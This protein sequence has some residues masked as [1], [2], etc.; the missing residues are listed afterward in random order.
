MPSAST[1]DALAKMVW[2]AGISVPVITCWTKQARENSDPDMARIMD[3]CNFYPRWKIVEELTPAL[4][5]LRREEPNSPLAITELQG[6]WFSEI[7]GVLS[8]NQEGVD[9]AQINMLTKTASGAGGYL[10][11]LLHG[12]RRDQFRLGG[13]EADHH[14]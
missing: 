8:V 9:A 14:L 5:K 11:Q 2:G 7:G 4:E 12:L 1:F 13:E 6:G 3:T 10:F